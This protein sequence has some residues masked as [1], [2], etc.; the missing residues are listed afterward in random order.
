L[1]GLLGLPISTV[2]RSPP[3]SPS[4]ILRVTPL[5]SPPGYCCSF[6]AAITKLLLKTT[7][8]RDPFHSSPISPSSIHCDTV[9]TE[10]QKKKPHRSC[11]LPSKMSVCA[12]RVDLLVCSLPLHRH[13]YI[14]FILAF[15][16]SFH[17]KQQMD[18]RVH[19]REP[20]S[21]SLCYSLTH[22]HRSIGYHNRNPH[23]LVDSPARLMYLRVYDNRDRSRQHAPSPSLS[24]SVTHAHRSIGYRNHHPQPLADSSSR[25]MYLR[26][27]DLRYFGFL[28]V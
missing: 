23:P 25:L 28:S 19:E 20:S 12:R 9:S 3:S 2:R 7:T 24:Y 15:A 11:S 27:Y 16:S 21:P 10:S 22:V 5:F 1:K 26:V 8:Y 4:A 17:N 18:L 6:P 13:S 14:G